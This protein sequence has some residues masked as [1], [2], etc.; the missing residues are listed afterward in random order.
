MN[1]LQS[2]IIRG[3][4]RPLI[5][6]MVFRDSGEPFDLVGWT[7]ITVQFRKADRT[8]LEKDSDPVGGV[9]ATVLYETVNYTAVNFGLAGNTISLV[10]DGVKDIATVVSDWNTANPTNTITHDAPSDLVVPTASTV[11]LVGG[12]E[13][14]TSV[15]VLNETLSKISIDLTDV[16][17]NSLKVGPNQSFKVIVDKGLPPEGD[18]RIVLFDSKL[19]VLNADI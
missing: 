10:F 5:V 19:N 9:L 8:I 1:N 13:Q 14:T 15:E 3:E 6:R 7:K 11:N 2:T 18:R 16:D 17:T 4:D 12:V